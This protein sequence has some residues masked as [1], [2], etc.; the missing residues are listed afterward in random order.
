MVLPWDRSPQPGRASGVSACGPAARPA[1]SRLGRTE[2]VAV[3]AEEVVRS[4]LACSFATSPSTSRSTSRS[5][6]PTP[7]RANPAQRSSR[8]QPGVTL[9]WPATIRWGSRRSGMSGLLFG[10]GI[11]D[12]P[13]SPMAAK[14]RPFAPATHPAGR[15][16]RSDEHICIG[17]DV[18]QHTDHTDHEGG[19]RELAAFRRV[20]SGPAEQGTAGRESGR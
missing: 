1:G 10:G 15:R 3:Q 6:G 17:D 4:H 7:T 12:V 18:E 5:C 9:A 16:I 14:G 13:F 11:A 19:L 8:D 20:D 2:H